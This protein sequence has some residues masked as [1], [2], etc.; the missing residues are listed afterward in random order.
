MKAEI[1]RKGKI[2]NVRNS[3]AAQGQGHSVDDIVRNKSEHSMR[4]LKPNVSF[5]K[6]SKSSKNSTRIP[7]EETPPCSEYNE[8]DDFK[9]LPAVFSSE[10][11]SLYES[12]SS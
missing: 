9:D 10:S 8:T 11:V 2:I 5:A 4:R 3:I 7:R 1:F 6:I 12:H